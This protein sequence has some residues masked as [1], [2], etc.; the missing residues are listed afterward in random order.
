MINLNYHS[1][2]MKNKTY[3][4]SKLKTS[5]IL[6]LWLLLS[7][8]KV[9]FGTTNAETPNSN[10]TKFNFNFDWKFTKSDPANADKVNFDDSAWENISCP[11]TFNDDDTFDDYMVGNHVGEAN[12]WR[13]TAISAF[14]NVSYP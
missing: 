6:T 1:L 14:S 2:S 11:H 5:T 7:V 4:F 9:S 12:Q 10:R 13:G 8:C 3:S